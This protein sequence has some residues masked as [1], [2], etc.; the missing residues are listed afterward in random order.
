MLNNS[1]SPIDRT[2]SG[3]TNLNQS[4]PNINGNEKVL[5]NPQSSK[6]GT[7]PSDCLMSYPGHSLSLT[8]LQSYSQSIIQPQSAGLH[9]KWFQT[10]VPK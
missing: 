9:K 8:S 1:I 10:C 5:H 3:A 4:R 6:T 7:S 2:L